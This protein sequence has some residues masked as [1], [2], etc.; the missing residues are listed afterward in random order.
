MARGR[1]T[2]KF[3]TVNVVD[4]EGERKRPQDDQSGKRLGSSPSSHPAIL[5]R[6]CPEFLASTLCLPGSP[7]SYSRPPLALDLQLGL[8]PD[9]SQRRLG[10][11]DGSTLH[12]QAQV[13]PEK[14]TLLR[15]CLNNN[16]FTTSH[17]LGAIM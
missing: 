12:T 10:H 17:T 7:L 2:R 16:P 8:I 1:G 15:V 5:S 13:P 11:P 3:Q 14:A 9:T 6:Y 4:C